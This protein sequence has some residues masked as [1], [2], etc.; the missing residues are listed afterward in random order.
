VTDIAEVTGAPVEDASGARRR[1][2]SGLEAMLLPELKQLASTLGIKGSGAMRK[3]QLIA[4]IQG[5]Q[6]GGRRQARATGPVRPTEEMSRTDA[7]QVRT[8]RKS[9]AIRTSRGR[10]PATVQRRTAVATR[11]RG[12]PS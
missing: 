11:S 5:S 2:G 7:R 9:S 3:G 8:G 12:N 10:P 6:Q 4:A 1:R